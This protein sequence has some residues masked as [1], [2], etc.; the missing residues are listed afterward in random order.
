MLAGAR[1]RSVGVSWDA[2]GAALIEDDK[3]RQPVGDGGERHLLIIRRWVP[4]IDTV[5]PWT[6]ATTVMPRCRAH[7]RESP[8][9][10][11]A[12]HFRRGGMRTSRRR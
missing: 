12:I 11:V 5:V 9:R 7:A 2:N 4:T 3:A 6:V 10:G 8:T 1:S